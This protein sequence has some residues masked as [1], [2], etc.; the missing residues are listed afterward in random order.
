VI[1]ILGNPGISLDMAVTTNSHLT[2]S[3]S[4]GH[5]IFAAHRGTGAI[6]VTTSGAVT[7]S[8]RSGISAV[9]DRTGAVRIEA[10]GAVT[11]D[12]T[13]GIHVSGNN[14]P[15]TD[16]LAI[17]LRQTGESRL[18]LQPGFALT[19]ETVADATRDNRLVFG[20]L[21]GTATF[22]LADW[23]DDNGSDRQRDFR[24]QADPAQGR[25]LHLHRGAGR[26]S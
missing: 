11:D 4:F 10:T 20:G 5:R 2:S 25:R 9:H 24:V 18:E 17:D 22:N 14:T 6:M 12:G 8:S 15:A 7:G 26:R 19:G 3:G 23:D 1:I 13:A 21:A 16:Q